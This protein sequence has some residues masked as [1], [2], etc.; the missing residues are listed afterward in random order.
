M[1]SAADFAYDVC[2]KRLQNNEE[3]TEDKKNQFLIRY[4]EQ[5]YDIKGFLRYHPGGKKTLGHF[6][7]RSLDKVF[8]DNPHSKAAF[9]LLED[10]ILNNQE[11]YQEYED[12]IDWNAPILRQVGSLSN[13]YWEWMNLPVNRPIRLFESNI[14]EKLS[15]TPWYLVPIVWIPLCIY[16]LYSG[17]LCV[18]DSYNGNTLFE[19]LISYILGILIWS[20]LEYVLHR[21]LFHFKP[22]ATSKLLISIH[23]ILHGVHHK[24]PFDDRRLVFPPVPGLLIA[25]LILYIYQALFSQT[26]FNFIGAGT[27]TG[28]ISY[29]LIHYYLHHGAPKDGTFLYLLK[30]N[31]NYHHFLHHELGFGISSKL[32][33]YVFG[34][35]ISLRQ[36][37]KP[38]EW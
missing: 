4:R 18:T 20:I 32:W 1:A 17:W 3:S 8:D 31:H 15:I 28:Y 14:L 2:K 37:T 16:F 29:D 25:T 13:R 21:K 22:P 6:K 11:K 23:F 36:L 12:L 33:D 9:H 34:T 10:F 38:I 35:S 26:M 27:I 19:V 5:L 7:N 24:A 30:R